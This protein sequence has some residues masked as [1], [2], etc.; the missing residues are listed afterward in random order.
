MDHDNYETTVDFQQGLGVELTAQHILTEGDWTCG[1][2]QN[3][4]HLCRVWRGHTVTHLRSGVFEEL[5][6]EVV[7]PPH[8]GEA[9][10]GVGRFRDGGFP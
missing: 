8:A 10:Q 4:T 3:A 9:F 7:A 6:L 5:D 2:E 1:G